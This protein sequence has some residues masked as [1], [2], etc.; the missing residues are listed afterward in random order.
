[1][2]Y[3]TQ[4]ELDAIWVILLKYPECQIVNPNIPEHQNDCMKSIK[5][6]KT[7][8]KEIGYFLKLTDDCHI[9]CFL[10]YYAGRW[11]AGSAAEANYML[12]SG[13][14]IYQI[15][16]INKTLTPILEPV[17]SYTFK[18]TLDKLVAHGI[19]KYIV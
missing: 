12:D 9:G 8:G 10:Q 13:K 5:G 11:S 16:I 7:P 18:E 6:D 14:N 4:M 2:T 1:M 17:E 3:N 15:D 19:R